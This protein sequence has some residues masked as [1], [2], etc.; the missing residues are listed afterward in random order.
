MDMVKKNELKELYGELFIDEIASDIAKKL[1]HHE[2]LFLYHL[3]PEHRQLLDTILSIRGVKLPELLEKLRIFF[4][5]KKPKAKINENLYE[6]NKHLISELTQQLSEFLGVKLDEKFVYQL[7]VSYMRTLAHISLM[8]TF[9]FLGI[10]QHSDSNVSIDYGSLGTPGRIAKMWSCKNICD[11][12]EP[13]SGR[14]ALEPELVVF[15]AKEEDVGKPVS[16]TLTINA[17]C[18][19]HLFRFGNEFRNQKSRAVISYI[20]KDK[21]LGLSKI[22]R[23]VE[24]V[25]RRGWLQEELT[26]YIGHKLRKKLQTKDIYVGLINMLHGCVS[27]RGKNDTLA[28]TTTE[29]YSGKY[30]DV[31]F[32]KA[33]LESLS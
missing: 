33:I 26:T 12:S 3:P 22:N 15:P 7:L 18:S 23:W 13:L 31:E 4:V 2:K 24:W 11:L 14:F 5:V 27:F 6:T 9:N 16:V 19:H 29:F 20:P 10:E 30:A 25:V 28:Y 1:D 17:M 8:V 21:V 32:R